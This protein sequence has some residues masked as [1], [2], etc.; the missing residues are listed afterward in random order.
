MIL[1]AKNNVLVSKIAINKV[2]LRI[3]EKNMAKTVYTFL[4]SLTLRGSYSGAREKIFTRQL[5]N[6]TNQECNYKEINFD[7]NI[8]FDI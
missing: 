7:S 8:C 4:S 2:N 1:Q 6:K 5:K 3:L